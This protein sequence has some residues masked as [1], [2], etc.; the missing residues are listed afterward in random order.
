VV[1][2]LAAPREMSEQMEPTVPSVVRSLLSVAGAAVL[3]S[4]DEEVLPLV[5]QA[6]V[7]ASVKCRA[8]LTVQMEQLDKEIKVAASALQEPML[9]MVQ[10][11][12]ALVVTVETLSLQVPTQSLLVR[13]ELEQHLQL[14]E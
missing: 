13:V 12:V 5:V 9:D 3:I 11:V 8:I 1:A 4:L 7:Q 10:A 2:V 6:V 14:Q